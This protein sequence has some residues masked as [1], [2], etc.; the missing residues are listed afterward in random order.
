MLKNEVDATTNS[1]E[2]QAQQQEPALAENVAV[3]LSAANI[4]VF[5]TVARSQVTAV[6]SSSSR[7][8]R[9]ALASTYAQILKSG[10]CVGC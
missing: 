1:P 3:Q 9:S 4:P 8:D 6:A 7:F 5:E 10:G 2:A